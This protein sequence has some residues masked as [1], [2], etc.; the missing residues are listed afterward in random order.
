[1]ENP[2]QHTKNVTRCG[3]GSTNN[4]RCPESN[5]LHTTRKTL[6]VHR[7]A[8]LKN[9]CRQTNGAMPFQTL[10]YICNSVR[11]IT[12]SPQPALTKK[13]SSRVSKTKCQLGLLPFECQA[14]MA[15]AVESKDHSEDINLRN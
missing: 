8:D 12:P 7:R 13:D 11:A 4:P 15:S 3:H 14:S 9:I 6:L 1:M 10:G 2:N 5:E